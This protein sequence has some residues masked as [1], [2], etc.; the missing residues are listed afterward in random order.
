MD[1]GKTHNLD[2]VNFA[3]PPGAP[4][5][6][7]I[8]AAVEPSSRP[9]IY[10]GGPVWA[11]KD[12][13]GKV[14][15]SNAKERDFLHYYT[16]QFNTIELNLTHYQIPTAGMIEKWRAEATN[17]FT[18]CPKFPQAISHER[19]L[20]ASEALTEEFVNAVLGLEEHLGMT[21][22]Q[23]P[24]TFGPDKWSVLEAYLKSLP[25]ELDVAVEF[26]HPDWF[27]PVTGMQTL[28]GLY[29]LRRHT[30]ITDVA[31]RRDVLHMGLS[32]P[33]LTLRFVANEGHPTDYARA[34]AWVQRLKTWFEK[35]LQ[36]AYLFIHGGGDNATAPELILYW[37]REL[38][39][40]CGLNLREPVLQPKVVQG[41]LF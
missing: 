20:I 26:R 27:K 28:E 13:V 22:L 17:G 18:Y 15:P 8:W 41:S 32:S 30:V 3:L 36:T 2:V 38:N 4:S 31:G 37:T 12:Y 23:L 33:V 29:A 34:D 6:A 7:R 11:N 40:H 10:I 19:H 39:K 35:G 25:D 21:F 24:P 5:N 1:F 14:Y 16:R 9:Q